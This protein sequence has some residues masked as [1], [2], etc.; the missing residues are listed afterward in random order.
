V[1]MRAKA[2][3]EDIDKGARQ[4]IIVDEIPYQ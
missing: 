1:I 2:H 4:A 3:F